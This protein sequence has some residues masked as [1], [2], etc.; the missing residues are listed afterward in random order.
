MC[1][2]VC[3]GGVGVMVVWNAAVVWVKSRHPVL[4]L[5]VQWFLH[6]VSNNGDSV[7]RW[8]KRREDGWA[9][10]LKWNIRPHFL[11]F[12][13]CRTRSAFIIY[14]RK[15]I[16]FC[17]CCLCYWLIT[18][19]WG[20]LPPFSPPSFVV[21]PASTL[22][23]VTAMVGRLL[24]HPS[25]QPWSIQVNLDPVWFASFEVTTWILTTSSTR[26]SPLSPFNHKSQLWL[27]PSDH[28]SASCYRRSC[29]TQL[30]LI[31]KL[32]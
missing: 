8:G 15:E 30:V 12:L 23:Q 6:L 5:K 1:L 16:Y 27:Q 18:A 4:V 9:A 22:L 3:G 10:A 2:C 7:A 26:S 25:R 32:W 11:W 13:L 20:C 24:I 21:D 17:G 14:L 19:G 31:M 28:P 29:F